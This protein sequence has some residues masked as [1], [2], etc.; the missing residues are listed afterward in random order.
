[1]GR[2]AGGGAGRRRAGAGNENARQWPGDP[3]IAD[4][5]VRRSREKQGQAALG[6]A[7]SAS[8][9]TRRQGSHGTLGFT[10]RRW[11]LTIIRMLPAL[12]PVPPIV[13]R[14]ASPVPSGL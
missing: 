6:A 8:E 13:K 5:C 1:M 4:V 9:P 11:H 2:K 10:G 12:R 14:T 7:A 3:V